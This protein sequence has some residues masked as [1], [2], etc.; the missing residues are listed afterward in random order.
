MK[1]KTTV[2]TS[3]DIERELRSL[4]AKYGISSEE[5]Y[6]KFIRGEM[7]DSREVVRWSGLCDMAAKA[8]RSTV[9]IH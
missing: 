7:G 5:F 9:G 8:K 2:L 4:E 3:A 6:E 1:A